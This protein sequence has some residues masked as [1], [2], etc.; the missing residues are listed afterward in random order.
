MQRYRAR[1]LAAS[2]AY[3]AEGDARGRVLDAMDG[4]RDARV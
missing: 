2:Q 1:T 3:P 4:A